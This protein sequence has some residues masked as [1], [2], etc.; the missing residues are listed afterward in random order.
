MS[1]LDRWLAQAEA[2]TAATFATP[3]S[4]PLRSEARSVAVLL[5]RAATEPPAG[6]I[7]SGVSRAVAIRLRRG[8]PQDS[9]TPLAVSQISQL[10]QVVLPDAG[11]ASDEAVPRDTEGLPYAPCRRCGDHVFWRLPAPVSRDAP[12]HC[13]TCTPQPSMPCDAC[14]VPAAANRGV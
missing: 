3:A 14:A 10:S 6:T 7:T 8:K 4:E 5:R 13:R 11:E 1:R 12:W 9:A 2:A